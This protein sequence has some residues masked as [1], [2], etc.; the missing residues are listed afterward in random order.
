MGSADRVVHIIMCNP[1]WKFSRL[2]NS[3][4]FFWGGGWGVN[5]S[6]RD[7]LGFCWKP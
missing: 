3:A 1:F 5:F 6:S 2:G 4:C 7:F